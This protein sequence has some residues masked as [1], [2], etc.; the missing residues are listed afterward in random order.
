MV[1]EATP[2]VQ[3]I[4]TKVFVEPSKDSDQINLVLQENETKSTDHDKNESTTKKFSVDIISILYCNSRCVQHQYSM[5]QLFD[6]IH[7]TTVRK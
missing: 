6:R 7:H 1:W 3:K 4:E 2:Q 5:Q